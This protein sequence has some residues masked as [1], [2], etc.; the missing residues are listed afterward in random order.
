MKK[1]GNT[2]IPA[3]ELCRSIVGM[4][5]QRSRIRLRVDTDAVSSGS[6]C[7]GNIQNASIHSLLATNERIVTVMDTATVLHQL[8]AL[9]CPSR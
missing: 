8:P 7:D 1:E 4:H 9:L 2:H 6:D 5:T 3:L